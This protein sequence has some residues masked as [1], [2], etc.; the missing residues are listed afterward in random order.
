[1]NLS[2]ISILWI[3]IIV[4]VVGYVVSVT[5]KTPRY[6]QQSCEGFFGGVVRGAGHPDCLRTLQGAAEIM[7][8]FLQHKETAEEGPADYTELQ[9]ILSK[10]ACLKKDLL[11]PSGIVEATRYQPYAA[12]HDREPIAEVTATCLNHT[13]P[14]RDLDIIFATFRD[15]GMFL[16]RRLCTSANLTEAE[17]KHLEDVYHKSWMDVYEIAK[18]RCLASPSEEMAKGHLEKPYTPPEL[19]DMSP[20][21]GYYSG[22]GGQI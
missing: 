14:K 6:Q 20:Y 13:I 12:T 22:W 16:L 5:V 19:E 3:I 2:I 11:S 4:I 10:L 18:G 8:A 21:N 17:S 15:R 9:L 7:G 1:M